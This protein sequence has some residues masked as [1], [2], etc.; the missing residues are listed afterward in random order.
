MPKKVPI[1]IAL[2]A[3]IALPAMAQNP[4]AYV[5]PAPA[6]RMARATL[7]DGFKAVKAGSP[8][9]AIERFYCV[10]ANTPRRSEA[11]GTANFSLGN[12]ARRSGNLAYAKEYYRRGF[13]S[14]AR[15]APDAGMALANVYVVEGKKSQAAEAFIQVRQR[16]P[17]SKQADQASLRTGMC[18]IGLAR[19]ANGKDQDALKQLA[20]RFLVD[21][22]DPEA[23]IQEC[24]ILWEF[25]KDGKIP[26]RQALSKLRSF[27]DD[28]PDAPDSAKARAVLM[29]AEQAYIVKDYDRCLELTRQVT[30]Q[31]PNCKT[32]YYAALYTESGALQDTR[33]DYEALTRLD[34]II[35]GCRDEWNFAGNNARQTATYWKIQS[36]K[37]LGMTK[38]AT[39]TVS[40]FRTTWPGETFYTPYLEVKVR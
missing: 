32:E 25:A 13:D 19:V 21:S 37:R 23:R 28:C 33:R 12:Y 31:Y 36:Q 4:A 26:W 14:G 24:G 35:G 16:Y 20:L 1:V 10:A 3:A 39:K 8:A 2:I 7:S 40:F 27:A 30:S 38:E 22:S 15:V 34:E 17:G 9:A 11:G 29:Q 5:R 18:Y 6:E